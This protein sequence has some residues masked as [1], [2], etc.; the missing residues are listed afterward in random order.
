LMCRAILKCR[1][2]TRLVLVLR[3]RGLHLLPLLRR[4]VGAGLKQC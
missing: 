3:K 1:S 2:L 4:E